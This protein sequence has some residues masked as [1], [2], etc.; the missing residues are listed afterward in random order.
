[1]DSCL[2]QGNLQ[3][4]KRTNPHPGFELRSLILFPTCITITLSA[5]PNTLTC[6]RIMNSYTYVRIIHMHIGTIVSVYVCVSVGFYGISTL[7]GYSMPNT[8]YTYILR[9]YVCLGW[10]LWH[11][12]PCWLFNAKYS[13]YIYIK[14]ICLLR[15]GF[16]AYQ[17]L[18]VIQCQILFIHIY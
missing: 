2:F 14:D 8:L 10:A 12:N 17:P 3:E 6:M 4:V 11:I 15:L 13:L 9:I 18:L 1:M 7:V 16:M 5:P